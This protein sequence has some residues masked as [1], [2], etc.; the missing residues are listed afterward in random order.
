LKAWCCERV[1]KG[2]RKCR[3]GADSLVCRPK[4][5][6]LGPGVTI[7]VLPA[8]FGDDAGGM[9]SL[10]HPYIAAIYGVE[11]RGVRS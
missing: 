4:H 11:D 7:K 2:V 6:K 9:A 1:F 3:K 10:N 5:S 8:A